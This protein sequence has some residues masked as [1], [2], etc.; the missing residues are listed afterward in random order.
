MQVSR[1][2]FE[3]VAMFGAT[4]KVLERVYKDKGKLLDELHVSESGLLL[5]CGST[6]RRLFDPGRVNCFA[7]K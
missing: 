2:Q 5:R 7:V 4:E 1:E 6:L 3:V